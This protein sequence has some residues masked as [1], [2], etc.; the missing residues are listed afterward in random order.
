M[1]AILESPLS[2]A[3]MEYLF[4][5]GLIQDNYESRTV[6]AEVLRKARPGRSDSFERGLVEPAP[7]IQSIIKRVL[8]ITNWGSGK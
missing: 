4:H 5:E 6:D 8:M 3:D 1:E 2:E 7:K